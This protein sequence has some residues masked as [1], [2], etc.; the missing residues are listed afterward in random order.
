MS[1]LKLKDWTFADACGVNGNEKDVIRM[2]SKDYSP[3]VDNFLTFEQYFFAE[4][5]PDK[6]PVRCWWRPKGWRTKAWRQQEDKQKMKQI[7][8]CGDVLDN[9]ELKD[10]YLENNWISDGVVLPIHNEDGDEYPSGCPHCDEK[11]WRYK[12]RPNYIEI[13]SQKADEEYKKGNLSSEN[14]TRDLELKLFKNIKIK[15]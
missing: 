9:K 2:L 1:K 12:E 5:I 11:D 6:N 3:S 10:W 13:L 7:L 8:T 14:R 4:N 15:F